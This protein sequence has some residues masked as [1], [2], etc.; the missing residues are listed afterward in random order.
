[1][2][3]ITDFAI[4]LAF[5]AAIA[6]VIL[7]FWKK[8]PRYGFAAAI[9]FISLAVI[10]LLMLFFATPSNNTLLSFARVMSVLFDVLCIM[11]GAIMYRFAKRREDTM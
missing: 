10:H 8:E 9:L 5:L 11:C 1:M 4:N 2:T 6:C 3:T 7:F